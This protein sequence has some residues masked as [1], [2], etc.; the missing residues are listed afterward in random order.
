MSKTKSIKRALISS[1][2]ALVMCFT[3]LIGTTYAW[4]TDSVTSSGNIIQSGTL[5]IAMEWAEGKEDPETA[6]WK[7]ASEVAIFDY[8]RWEPGY[9]AARHI[10]FINN[11]SLALK[12]E[13][14][15]VADLKQGETVPNLAEVIDVYYYAEAKKLTA[16]TFASENGCVKLGTLADVLENQRTIAQ[17]VTGILEAEQ[18]STLTLALH[19]KEDVGNEYQ[20]LSIGSS[21]SVQILATQCSSENEKD[22]FGSDYDDAARFPAYGSAGKLAPG[23]AAKEI[24]IY[25]TSSEKAGSIIVPSAAAA[26]GA[27]GF[28][29]R[30]VTSAYR[31]NFTLDDG[32]ES[33]TYDITVDGLRENNTTPVK[34]TLKIKEGL[35]PDTVSVYHYDTPIAEVTYDPSTGYVIF[36]TATFSPFTFVFDFDE[37]YVPDETKPENLPVPAVE[38]MPQYVNIDIPWGSYGQWSPTAGLG[39][40]LEAAYSFACTEDLAEAEAGD[41]AN[42]YCDFYVMLDRD[43]GEDQIFLGGNYGTIGWVGFHN[44]DFTLKADTE[45]ALLGSVTSNPWTYAQVVQN[46]G[47]F[48]CG[49]GD[50]DDALAGAT[51]TVK[52]RLTNPENENE[53]YD[54]ATVKYTFTDG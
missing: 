26:S 35:D 21:F 39:S 52:L 18:A 15:I 9:T 46:V 34:V 17:R 19:M 3:M 24:A 25:D 38:A 4:F 16:S 1:I 31:G 37:T 2:I 28:A 53:F 54:V 43:L 13:M 10:K 23:E 44:G 8:N 48:I 5:K 51:F 36:E 32:L 41:F 27:A 30:V 11:G 50:V 47:E 40:R 33:V 22:S 12:Y 45:L 7:D 49:V 6:T 42:W 29:A 14:R 20:G